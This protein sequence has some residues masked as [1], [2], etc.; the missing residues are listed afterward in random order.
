MTKPI[1]VLIVEDSPDD[2]ELLTL[3]LSRGGFDPDATRVQ[4]EAAM[5]AAL[6]GGRWDLI[7]ADHTVPGF[8]AL[9]ALALARE[10]DPDTPFL[11]VSGT[12]GEERAADL[13]RAGASDFVLKGSLVRLVP[14]VERELREAG[15]R[16][17]RRAAERAA[18][19][20]AA[21]VESTDDAVI[22]K[23]LDGT[24][25]SW[26]PAAERLYGWAA[27]EAVGRHISFIFPA[28]KR[29]ELTRIMAQ[30]RAG[31]RVESFESVRL[32]KDGGRIDVSL[33]I[34]PVRDVAGRVVGGSKIARDIRRRLRAEDALRA[35]E[36]R[37]RA[38]IGSMAEGLILADSGGRMLE[39]NEAALRLHGYADAAEVL[40]PLEWFAATYELSTPEGRR[41]PLAEWPIARILRGETF[42]GYELHVRRIDTGRAVVV[43]Y[44]GSPVLGRDGRVVLAALTL[45]DMTEH[46]RVE[47][48]RNRLLTRLRYQINRMPLGYVLLDERERVADWNPGAERIFGYSRDEVLGMGPPFEKI[49]APEDWPALERVR[50][51]VPSGEMAA[52][53]VN[54]YVTKDG[55]AITCE[56]IDTPLPDGDGRVTEVMCLV[57]DI[58]EKQ[59]LEERVR[60]SQKME[61]V[62]QL[63]AGVAHD[64]NNL[65]TIINGYSD[66]LLGSLP[67]GEPSWEL[68]EEIHRAGERSA[69]LTRQL[70]AFSRKE[71]VA[72]RLL[73]LNAVVTE[74]EKLLRRVIGE[75]VRL[76]TALA[77]DL[78]PVKVDPGQVD[79]V[80]LNLAVNARDAMPT[81]GRLTVET[82]NV[83]L[84]DEFVRT[85][86][87]STPGPY[88]LL[89]V[90]DTGCGM[91]GAVKARIFEP[92]F[93]TKGAGRGTGLGL[94]TVFGIIK[95]SRGLIDVY[96]EV[97]IGTT[98]KV[99]LPR[100]EP[101]ASDPGRRSGVRTPPRG[102]ETVLL[103]EDEDG[104]RALTRHVL[105][106]CGY[107]VL[108]AADG[109]EAVR[110][111]EVHDGP[112][113]LLVT[114]V[115]LPTIDGR[116]VAE[117][118]AQVHPDVRVLYVSGY[119]ADAVIHHGILHETVP[120]LQKPFAPTALAVKIRELLDQPPQSG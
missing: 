15:G 104:V 22:S 107:A 77:P 21:L 82:K 23:T 108:E 19:H 30:L 13:M 1:R 35:S 99:Y 52:H 26:N 50:T 10:A 2:A 102:T 100:V 3:E 5:R 86:P 25:T 112:I 9:P 56:W 89:A 6:A 114:D 39:W 53:S 83:E 24:I 72:P 29:D 88:V 97:G 65:L 48:E 40:R 66:L 38:V 49:V 87:D 95:Q 117:R 80:L 17:V 91:T 14:A 103:V 55:R 58:T 34:S 79:Q 85:H 31:E 110:A 54:R 18:A 70:L 62:G 8:G 64:F 98:F 16:R 11:V 118:V 27:A 60:Q 75:D 51:R 12:V 67:P 68:V 36:G 92:F 106:G 42:A 41:L 109:Q 69:G 115:V 45:H 4:D 116:T 37:L 57:Q 101:A 33:T 73:D 84:T 46:R 20:L 74:A 120:F 96:S 78:W 71:V 111:A 105:V 47:A 28:D 81:G 76:R 119:T 63:A 61:A 59:L 44:G 90:S 32:L 43:S 93:T 7:L 113:H 94:A